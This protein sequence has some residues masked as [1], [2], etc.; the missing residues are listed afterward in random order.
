MGWG[1]RLATAAV[2]AVGFVAPAGAAAH[3]ITVTPS[4]GLSDGQV[5]T[6]TGT[7]FTETPAVNDWSVTECRA[8]VLDTPLTLSSAVDNCDVLT[9]PFTFVHADAQGA[10]STPFTVHR[11]I[12]VQNAAVDC[13][14][15]ACVV[16]VAQITTASFDGAGAPISFGPTPPRPPHCTGAE[17]PGHGHGDRHHCHRPKPHRRH[18]TEREHGR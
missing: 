16:L 10:I 3:A 8:G 2:A 6:V 4:T 18:H 12:T 17:R 7:G 13:L 11:T 5:V 15:V 1:P 14:Q 9:Q